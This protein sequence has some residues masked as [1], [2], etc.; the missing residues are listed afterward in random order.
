MSKSQNNRPFF[1]LPTGEEPSKTGFLYNKQNSKLNN[2]I[3]STRSLLA[4]V[5]NSGL[6]NW[7][8]DK[9]KSQD[10]FFKRNA[11][12]Q[13]LF[14]MTVSDINSDI[15]KRSS[16]SKYGDMLQNNELT[17]RAS[18][19]TKNPNR[20][21]LYDSGNREGLSSSSN[22]F[23]QGPNKSSLYMPYVKNKKGSLLKQ[24]TKEVD[25]VLDSIDDQVSRDYNMSQ[26]GSM[27][28]SQFTRKSSNF[29]KQPT[30]KNSEDLVNDKYNK[31]NSKIN[32]QDIDKAKDY[33]LASSKDFKSGQD[34]NGDDIY[35][36]KQKDLEKNGEEFSSQNSQSDDGTKDIP[37][38]PT[39][40]LYDKNGDKFKGERFDTT[41]KKNQKGVHDKDDNKI[42]QNFYDPSGN[43]QNNKNK[44]SKKAKNSDDDKLDSKSNKI[45]DKDGKQFTWDRFDKSGKP[46]K[47]GQFDKQGNIIPNTSYDK[48]GNP[49]DDDSK[50]EK[51]SDKGDKQFKWDR[52]DAKNKKDKFGIFDKWGNQIRNT[53]YD[54]SGNPI[55]D[56]EKQPKDIHDKSGKKY[57]W[58]RYEKNGKK[59]INGEYDKLGNKIRDSIYD[60][61]G[62]LISDKN[63]G[64]I[65][66]KSGKEF[67]WDRFDKSGKKD[68]SGEYDK[69]GNKIRNSL[70]DDKGNPIS[71]KN[72][73]KSGKI[74]DKSGK[75]FIWDRYDK[76]SKKDPNGE[77]DKQGN[78]IRNSQYD[79][80]GNLISD[81]NS[82]KIFDKSGKEFTG[83]RYDQDGKKDKLGKYDK[84]GKKIPQQLYDKNGNP[85]SSDS[86]D[87]NR[88][89][90]KVNFLQK[91]WSLSL[92]KDRTNSNKNLDPNVIKNLQGKTTVG[93]EE[94]DIETKKSKDLTRKGDS[95]LDKHKNR[96]K[97]VYGKED[98]KEESVHEDAKEYEKQIFDGDEL[99]MKIA[100][101]KAP[102]EIPDHIKNKMN[103]D[104]EEDPAEKAIRLK[105]EKAKKKEQEGRKILI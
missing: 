51:I 1:K 45:H 38:T 17:P 86:D 93:D 36:Q 52:Y 76:N 26:R 73:D 77:F 5:G 42:P 103:F 24:P 89:K 48:N 102:I 27:N 64:K 37:K 101:A 6:K 69:K 4:T 78:K 40:N 39:I 94:S 74:H 35:A 71:D 21:S 54:D 95:A 8:L 81:K 87:E 98:E 57:T 41:G 65:H 97:F 25:D 66:D 68:S 83:D 14:P 30:Q 55:K 29:G 85:I 56:A 47:N 23:R 15:Q 32:D 70:Y 105:K 22:V 75:E 72:S 67:I 88:K 13:K 10:S 34:L 100:E 91:I 50:L 28:Q 63:S 43:L 12:P 96:E 7:D 16:L 33:S 3:E 2:E 90:N 79:D 11:K 53:Y 80:K 104:F 31:K 84:N 92:C 99:T 46:D 9:L 60:K 18:D 19:K 61:N 20:N 82:N 49:T 58:Q 62:N 44:D 59:N